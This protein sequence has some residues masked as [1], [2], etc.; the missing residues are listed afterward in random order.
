MHT[1]QQMQEAPEVF[2]KQLLVSSIPKGAAA[3][4]KMKRPARFHHVT[5]S[6]RSIITRCDAWH[7]GAIR[8]SMLRKNRVG[9]ESHV[10]GKHHQNVT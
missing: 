7:V 6:A 2:E 8:C 3:G 4:E 9:F 10:R 5:M 1:Q